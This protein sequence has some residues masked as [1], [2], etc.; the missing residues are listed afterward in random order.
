ML[1]LYFSMD[2]VCG[3]MYFEIN[4]YYCVNVKLKLKK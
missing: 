1:R 2:E 4:Y 3:L